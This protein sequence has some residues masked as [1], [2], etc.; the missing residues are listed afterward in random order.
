MPIGSVPPPKTK[1]TQS[2]SPSSAYY[3][4]GSPPGHREN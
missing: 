4:G 3:E 2:G 1:T